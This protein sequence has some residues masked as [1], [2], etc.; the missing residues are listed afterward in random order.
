M[1]NNLMLWPFHYPTIEFEM[2]NSVTVRWCWCWLCSRGA[3]D[4]GAGGNG[5]GGAGGAGGVVGTRWCCERE[6]QT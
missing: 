3:G 1:V 4:C 5:I 2:F 6:V